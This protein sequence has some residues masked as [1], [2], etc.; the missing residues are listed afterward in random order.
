MREEEWSASGVAPS[1]AWSDTVR[2]TG[3]GTQDG[4]RGDITL[5]PVPGP[6]LTGGDMAARTRNEDISQ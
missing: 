5:S 6:L 3:V 2:E 1:E 4:L